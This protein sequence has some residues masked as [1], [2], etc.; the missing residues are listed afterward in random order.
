MKVHIGR[1]PSKEGAIRKVDIRIDKW[2]A[3]SLDHT[4]ALIIAPSLEALKKTLHGYPSTILQ[5]EINLFPSQTRRVEI[6]TDEES[7]GVRKWT[8]ILDQMIWSFSEVA[9]DYPNAPPIPPRLNASE[10]EHGD[11]DKWLETINE[12]KYDEVELAKW[13]SDLAKYNARI[14]AGLMLFAKWYRNLWD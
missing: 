14:D 10:D 12:A 11:L 9:A 13:R 1:Y 4:L 6:D 8:G 5:E 2:D 7:E 3:W